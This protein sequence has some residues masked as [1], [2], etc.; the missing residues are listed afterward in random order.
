LLR[1]EVVVAW[2]STVIGRDRLYRL[3]GSGFKVL[4]WILTNVDAQST[5]ATQLATMA[6]GISLGRRFIRIGH[7]P[8]SFKLIVD[9][10]HQD[11]PEYGYQL[12]T[13]INRIFGSVYLFVDHIGW[14]SRLGL[15]KVDGEKEGVQLSICGL[16]NTVFS[17][18]SDAAQYQ[19]L[20]DQKALLEA[21]MSDRS[22]KSSELKQLQ[23]ELTSLETKVTNLHLNF[24]RNFLDIPPTA[25]GIWGW[26]FLSPGWW[27]LVVFVS[28]IV[29]VY[30]SLATF[31]ILL[32]VQQPLLLSNSSSAISPMIASSSS[33]S[34]VAS[35]SAQPSPLVPRTMPP[36]VTTTAP[37]SAALTLRSTLGISSN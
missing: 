29:G 16:G 24:I 7:M 9:T 15:F 2:L 27:S 36:A 23:L 35:L 19:L 25:Q 5:R 11:T 37:T 14:L 6:S 32:P 20:Q 30:Q 28:S 4:S 18:F 22:L 3:I 10:L 8:G 33:T 12:W 31:N 21:R 1:L 13:L 26:T 17:I 34:S